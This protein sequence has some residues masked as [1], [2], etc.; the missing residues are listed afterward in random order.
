MELG[1]K[2]SSSPE[3]QQ[4]LPGQPFSPGSS[5]CISTMDRDERATLH[6]FLQDFKALLWGLGTKIRFKRDGR[7]R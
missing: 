5:W 2:E 7:E 3:A 6:R 1:G 4:T